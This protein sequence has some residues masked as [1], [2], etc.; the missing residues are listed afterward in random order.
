MP[1]VPGT[2]PGSGLPAPV[3]WHRTDDHRDPRERVHGRRL[4]GRPDP[5]QAPGL[6]HSRWHR[7]PWWRLVGWSGT[8]HPLHGAAVPDRR[9]AAPGVHR[10]HRRPRDNHGPSGG[11][12]LGGGTT[13]FLARQRTGSPVHLQ[14]RPADPA[15]LLPRWTD[16]GRLLSPRRRTAVGRVAPARYD[17]NFHDNTTGRG[18]RRWT[19]PSG[20]RWARAGRRRCG[21][22]LRGAP[23]SRRRIARGPPGGGGRPHR[24]QRRRQVDTHER[25]RWFRPVHGDRQDPRPRRL[26]VVGG[27]PSPPGVGSNL[28]GSPPVPRTDRE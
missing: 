19:D 10:G 12:P 11:C 15:S 3:Y 9:L 6:R 7:R 25:H 27:Q 4:H 8:E 26:R 1:R 14:H 24:N 16:P 13:R 2:A 17:T 20:N 21:R 18:P 22:D 28:P 23:G 5:Y